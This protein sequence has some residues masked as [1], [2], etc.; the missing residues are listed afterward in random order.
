MY[1]C[2]N[3]FSA[4]I[5]L[6]QLELNDGFKPAKLIARFKEANLLKGSKSILEIDEAGSHILDLIVI[7]WVFVEKYRR[8]GESK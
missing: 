1:A 3:P 6:L 2:T 7:T 4:Y 5:H 8:D